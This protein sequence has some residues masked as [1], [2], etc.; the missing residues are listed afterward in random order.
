MTPKRLKEKNS[1]Y[2]VEE[3]SEDASISSCRNQKERREKRHKAQDQ[4]RP[5]FE[6]SSSSPE[7]ENLLIPVVDDSSEWS[8]EESESEDSSNPRTTRDPSLDYV[9]RQE[10]WR[11]DQRNLRRSQFDRNRRRSIEKPQLRVDRPS[12][13][14]EQFQSCHSLADSVSE[15]PVAHKKS[16]SRNFVVSHHAEVCRM[17]DIYVKPPRSLNLHRKEDLFE[18]KTFTW[19]EVRRIL[20]AFAIAIFLVFFESFKSH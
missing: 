17:S 20:V 18:E 3:S 12:D 5:N 2:V 7:Y 10:R 16:V 6:R 11:K 9:R 14:W 1:L 15:L 4:N 19:P 8:E 13:N